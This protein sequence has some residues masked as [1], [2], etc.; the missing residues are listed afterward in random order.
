MTKRDWVPVAPAW[1]RDPDDGEI[2]RKVPVLPS[3]ALNRSELELLGPVGGRM[4]AVLGVGDGNAALALAAMGAR[5]IAVDPSQ[6]MLDMLMVRARICGLEIDFRVSELHELAG[7]DDGLCQLAIAAQ[8]A[9]GC[10]DLAAF[11]SAAGRILAPGSRLLVTEYHP[12]RRIWQPESGSPRVKYSYFQ[13][14]RERDETMP[15]DPT[16]PGAELGRVEYQWTVSDHVYYLVAAGFRIA[17]LEEVGEVRQHW[18]VPNLRG[19]PEQLVIAAD[20][21]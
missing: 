13:R 15:P 9:P 21:F 18:E 14:I 8:L 17:A 10:A 20:R 19:L 3:L 1:E 4:T 5:V 6:S 16:R 7:L 12:I 11:Y 2:W